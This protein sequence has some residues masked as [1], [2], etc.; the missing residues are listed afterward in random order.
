MRPHACF[1]CQVSFT[2]GGCAGERH[3]PC[4]CLDDGSKKIIFRKFPYVDDGTGLFLLL[5]LNGILENDEPFEP[6]IV[7]HGKG[8]QVYEGLP[9]PHRKI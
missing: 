5:T 9:L 2:K 6:L 4:C 3:A 7:V 8:T 1:C